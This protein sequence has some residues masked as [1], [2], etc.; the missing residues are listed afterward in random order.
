MLILV[1]LMALATAPFLDYNERRL[2]ISG[3]T[4]NEYLGLGLLVAV[5]VLICFLLGYLTDGRSKGDSSPHRN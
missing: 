1:G 2:V 4:M 5:L 3:V